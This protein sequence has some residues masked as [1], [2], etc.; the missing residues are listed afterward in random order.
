M[1]SLPSAADLADASSTIIPQTSSIK[2]EKPN[3]AT[4]GKSIPLSDIIQPVDAPVEL[5]TQE[6]YSPP[7]SNSIQ[8]VTSPQTV[9]GSNSAIKKPAQIE[10]FSG[11][12]YTGPETQTTSSTYMPP[13]SAVIKPVETPLKVKS[14]PASAPAK[15]KPT[16]DKPKKA[17][18]VDTGRT[19]P[20]NEK[21]RLARKESQAEL[22]GQG[23]S[24]GRRMAQY[25]QPPYPGS[26]PYGQPPPQ[27]GYPPQQGYPPQGSP[28][29]QPPPQY[30]P[31]GYPPPSYPQYPPPGYFNPRDYARRDRISDNIDNFWASVLNKSKDITEGAKGLLFAVLLSAIIIV[32]LGIYVVILTGQLFLEQEVKLPPELTSD[33]SNIVTFLVGAISSYLFN[34]DKDY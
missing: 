7:E 9:T 28:Y 22:L 34:S 14:K 16:P 3:P 29:G 31:P 33:L 30:P 21:E 2:M 10:E 13:D 26:N 17:F 1:D 23:Q 5:A 24:S 25:G 19:A 8:P 20:L 4:T 32:W 12:R 15:T 18:S 11:A 6:A 27:H